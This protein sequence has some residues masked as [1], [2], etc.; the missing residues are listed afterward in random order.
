MSASSGDTDQIR[1]LRS[2]L[3]NTEDERDTLKREVEDLAFKLEEK[4]AQG[5]GNER[6]VL[7]HGRI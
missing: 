4:I 5:A 1:S 2:R 7:S 6:A 3:S